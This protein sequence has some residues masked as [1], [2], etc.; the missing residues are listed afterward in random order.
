MV[1][2]LWF[3]LDLLLPGARVE[4]Y[5]GANH[6]H[7]LLHRVGRRLVTDDGVVRSRVEVP[8]LPVQRHERMECHRLRSLDVGL[9]DHLELLLVWRPSCVDDPGVH[10]LP[11]QV[12][13]K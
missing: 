9:H 2:K 6:A 12:S 5:L 8:R 10:G 13:V 3:Q 11:T 4:L 7:V 1:V